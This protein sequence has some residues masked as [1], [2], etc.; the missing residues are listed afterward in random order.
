MGERTVEAVVTIAG[1]VVAVA[2]IA[3][4]VSKK[5]NTPAVVQSVAS[6]FNNALAVAEAPVTGAVPH[7]VLA[8]PTAG[9][10]GV[11]DF[12]GLTQFPYG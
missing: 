11:N 9:F 1:F 4:L 6:G 12:A 2:I 3:T 5:A 10:G 8:Y 7:P